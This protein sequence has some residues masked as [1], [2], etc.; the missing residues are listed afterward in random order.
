MIYWFAN[1][2]KS[3]A[4]FNRN[5]KMFMLANVLIQVG[6]GVFLVMYNLYIKELGFPETLNGKI[7][8]MTSLASAIMLI[9]A[10]YLSDR[11]GRKGIIITGAIF[12]A[13]TLFYRSLITGEQSLVYAAFFTGLF[14]ALVQVSGVPFL[15]ENSTAGERMHLFSIHFS[16][17]TIASVIGSLGG[18]VLADA[19]HLIGNISTVD[20]IMYVLIIGAIIFTMGIVP[21]F[22]LKPTQKIEGQTEASTEESEGNAPTGFRKNMK[23]IVLFGVANLLIGTGSGLVIPYLNLYFAN[24]FDA[25]NTY[26]GIILSLGS[27]MAAVAML[28]GPALVKKVG[29]VK[30]LV[31]FQLLSIPFLFITG[32]TNSLIIASIAFL[33]RQALMN[34]GNPIQSA[35]A[36]ELVQDKYKGLANSVNQMVFNVGWASTGAI[37]TGLVMTFGFYWGYAY[38]FTITGILYIIASTYFY[39][40]FGR[41]RTLRKKQV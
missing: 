5:I 20:S 37:S 23:V 4:L 1:W 14:M 26:I 12:A 22:Q 33:M 7:I 16:L 31:I 8:S 40:L 39:L 30:A 36:M 19:L 41:K 15:A 28:L 32:Y 2:K 17:M 13:G 6:M 25:S 29:K 10:G 24:R 34:A 11:L 21:L 27:A 9:P 18:G 3:F 35:I 38:T